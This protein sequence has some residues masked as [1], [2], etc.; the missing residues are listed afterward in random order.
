MVEYFNQRAQK[1]FSLVEMAVVLVIIGLIVAAVSAG[2]DTMKSAGHMKA[3]QKLVVPC[4]AMAARKKRTADLPAEEKDSAG[5]IDVDGYKCVVEAKDGDTKTA[6]AIISPAQVTELDDFADTVT[7]KLHNKKNGVRV[8]KTETDVIVE[9]TTAQVFLTTET[10]AEVLAE[11][12][13][14]AQAEVQAEAEAEAAIA[15]AVGPLPLGQER[16]RSS[17]F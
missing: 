17:R 16:V 12:E 13:A 8:I 1:G 11:A 6:R 14:E 10:E 4:V 9:V 3:Y 5:K 15:T 7:Q 2:R